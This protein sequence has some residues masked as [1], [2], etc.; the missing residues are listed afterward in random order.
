MR[1][2]LSACGTIETARAMG[3]ERSA[4]F[5]FFTWLGRAWRKV[6]DAFARALLAVR[7]RR[8]RLEAEARLVGAEVRQLGIQL[9]DKVDD[10]PFVPSSF[11]VTPIRTQF[12]G[13]GAFMGASPALL[14]DARWRRILAFLMP[15][16]FEQIRKA[17][18]TGAGPHKIM[19]MLENNPVLAAFGVYRS[20][21]AEPLEGEV[22]NP[23]HLCGL[24]WDLFVDADLFPVWEKARGDEA[25]MADVMERMI[26]TSLIAHANPT[27]TLQEA[28]GICQ[29]QDVRKT[30]KTELGGVE[31]DSW[32]DL[33]ARALDLARAPNVGEAITAM[34]S[35]P[36]SDSDEECMRH[37][38][39]PPWTVRKA[40]E[41]HREVTGKPC[42]SVIIEIKSLRSTPEF[43]CDVV[44]AMNA[45][46]VHVVA[47]ASFLREEVVG[48]GATQQVI[49][50]VPY[51]GPRE[52]QFFHFAGDLQDA[53]DRGLVDSGQSVMFNGASLLETAKAEGGRPVYSTKMTVR[54]ELEKYRERLDLHVG[55]YV[56]E[57]D[58]DHQAASLLS[59]LCE[60]YPETFELGFA[61][62]GL[63][64]EAHI[65]SSSAVRLGYG[66]QRML[67]YV[68]KAKQW[69]VDKTG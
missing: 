8:R 7:R 56:Q 47:V 33:F 13:H 16:V 65:E 15:D 67:E 43:L 28:M 4:R 24:E 30:P 19:P 59:D 12:Y 64:D 32:L 57:G 1:R 37:T 18:A 54:A 46:G 60:A 29:Y 52:I 44:R 2:A 62:G 45:R 36:R 31:V 17:L 10:L 20:A 11:K 35:D 21:T 66:S 69:K 50:G 58:C 40:V 68:G 5:R 48:V 3:N 39:A 55:F 42:I 23:L 51:P 41:V 53:C 63:R 22:D 14:A 38:F 9:W 27:D 25:A 34:E 26:D 61:W 6:E 49:D